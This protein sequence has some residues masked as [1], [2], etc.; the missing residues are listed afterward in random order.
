MCRVT[1]RRGR[2]AIGAALV[3]LAVTAGVVWATGGFGRYD[4]E[5]DAQAAPVTV[6]L[7]RFRVAVDGPATVVRVGR[8]GE[9]P[10]TRVR[11]PVVVELTDRVAETGPSGGA[12]TAT[13]SGAVSDRAS[14]TR[15]VPSSGETDYEPYDGFQPWQGPQRL[16]WEFTFDR[17]VARA[18]Q[19]GLALPVERKQRLVRYGAPADTWTTGA[20]VVRVT[21][22]TSDGGHEDY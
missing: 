12:E 13:M 2:L 18:G 14:L 20:G 11:V 21:V 17:S 15:A 8:A 1:G 19:V 6:D 4:A 3:A 9:K 16:V 22:R 7:G 5:P 10:K